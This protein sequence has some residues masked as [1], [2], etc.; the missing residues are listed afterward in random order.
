MLSLA[1]LEYAGAALARLAIGSDRPLR[2]KLLAHWLDTC[3]RAAELGSGAELAY[4]RVAHEF[5]LPESDV[6]RWPPLADRHRGTSVAPVGRSLTRRHRPV[7]TAD[8]KR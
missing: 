5:D 8:A 2:R 7:P 3:L 6:D 1:E 4:R